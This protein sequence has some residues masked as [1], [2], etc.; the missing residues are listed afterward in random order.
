MRDLDTTRL[1]T[2]PGFKMKGRFEIF[3]RQ[4]E[5][6]KVEIEVFFAIGK[7]I[8]NKR[9]DSSTYSLQAANYFFLI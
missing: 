5:Q 2:T 6:T 4:F 8:F 3:S 9:R 1:Q 7:L